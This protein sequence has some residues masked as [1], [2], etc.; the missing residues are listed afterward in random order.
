VALKIGV[1]ESRA[2]AKTV[3]LEGRLNNETV[4]A[5]DAE[6]ERIANSSATVVVLDL[7]G[8][9]YISSVGLRS[10]FRLQK[11]MA[12]R[13]GKALLVNPQPQVQKVFQIVNAADISAVFASVQELDDYL[14]LMQRKVLDGE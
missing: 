13:S 5:F 14:D 2:F 7:A 3:H 6:L 1:T 8:L 9:D 10:I 11:T 12:A 4:A